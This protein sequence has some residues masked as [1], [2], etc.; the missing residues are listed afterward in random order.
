MHDVMS[1]CMYVMHACMYACMYVFMWVLCMYIYIHTQGQSREQARE[2]PGELLRRASVQ[3]ARQSIRIMTGVARGY[4]LR[5]G[6][7]PLSLQTYLAQ[8]AEAEMSQKKRQ[9]AAEISKLRREAA[10][11]GRPWAPVTVNQQRCVFPDTGSGYVQVRPDTKKLRLVTRGFTPGV[12]PVPGEAELEAAE[13]TPRP[14]TGPFFGA[15]C[16]VEE[17]RA[18]AAAAAEKMMLRARSCMQEALLVG[19]GIDKGLLRQ[20]RLD[21]GMGTQIN[22]VKVIG[23][24]G[25]QEQSVVLLHGFGTGLAVWAS[26]IRALSR[27]CTRVYALDL[28]GHALSSDISDE[29]TLSRQKSREGEKG[30]GVQEREAGG[31]EGG[32]WVATYS[33]LPLEVEKIEVEF[34]SAIENW[35]KLMCAAGEPL[36][37]FSIVGH[38]LG[39]TKILK[40]LCH[41]PFT[42]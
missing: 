6:S 18:L 32:G 14:Q 28:P 39:V 31:G 30:E 22:Y 13:P 27:V 37:R 9:G 41:I 11:L 8:Q 1:V 5:S 20:E 25:A 38:S 42:T 35:R 24:E 19:V 29:P 17:R 10:K 4:K 36:E 26:T 7:G 40:S 2:H 3:V 23:S 12:L 34:L 16:E 33:G 15:E 21:V